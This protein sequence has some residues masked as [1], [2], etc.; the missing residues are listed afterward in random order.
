[1]RTTLC[2]R[3]S[4][5]CDLYVNLFRRP[6]TRRRENRGI[7]SA[8]LDDFSRGAYSYVCT[9]GAG[10]P[11]RLAEPVDDTL[12]FAGEATDVSGHL[13]TVHGAIASGRRAADEIVASR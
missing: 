13:G 5:V 6:T 3:A 11:H 9:G 7:G 4:E 10:A 8:V 2:A 1:M 12:F